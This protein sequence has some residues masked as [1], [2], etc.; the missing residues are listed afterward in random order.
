[1]DKTL[2]AR[3]NLDHLRGQAKT[4]LAQL[5]DG[6]AGAVRAFR[7]HLPSARGL[8]ARALAA[9]RI[10][11][12]DAQSV[13]ARQ[14][15]FASWPQL[16]RHVELLRS[17][18]GEWHITSLEVD[19]AN[20]P[21]V[22]LAGSRILI[23]GDRFRTESPEAT[24][25]GIYTI[26]AEASPARIDIEFIAGPEA[27]NTS[28]GIFALDGDALT[29]CLGLVGSSRPEGFA[30]RPGSGHALEQLSRASKARPADVT[31]GT[32][33]PARE[34]VAVEREDRSAFEVPMTPL[35]RRL[36]GEWSAVELVS[37]GKPLPAEWLAYGSRTMKGNELKVV[38]GG[39]TMVHAL[40]R[41]D[42]GASPIAVD[43]LDLRP[44]SHG[45]L[46]RGILEWIDGDVRFFMAPAG[47]PRPAGFTDRPATGTLSRWC[48][49]H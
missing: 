3:P 32:P 6:D 19:G 11:L 23:D 42:E 8:D 49:K 40:V 44:K 31:G 45:V 20:V 17:L 38:F 5:K 14:N 13:V 22:A 46:S 47:D 18:E 28:H 37:D 48:R 30:T 43:Y 12:A 4:L 39:Q 33:P 34:P 2:P 29:L 35:M 9:A 25:E 41:I 16:T 7:D 1:M 27:G 24:Y 15:G 36:E 21:R 10:R 26:D